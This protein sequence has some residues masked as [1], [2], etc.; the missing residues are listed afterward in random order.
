MRE[1]ER[2]HLGIGIETRGPRREA[3][4]KR[5]VRGSPCHL[6]SAIIADRLEK[7]DPFS[8]HPRG[9]ACETGT[10][11]QIEPRVCLVL[12]KTRRIWATITSMEAP[13]RRR[14]DS[15]SNSTL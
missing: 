6:S 12:R 3:K 1:R 14:A 2:C 7:G 11:H 4:E 8:F 9:I 5:V 15:N 10:R 13:I